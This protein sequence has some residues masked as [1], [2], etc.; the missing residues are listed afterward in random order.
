MNSLSV[1]VV[2]IENGYDNEE[3]ERRDNHVLLLEKKLHRLRVIIPSRY[4]KDVSL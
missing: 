2:V 4:E 3:G 1:V